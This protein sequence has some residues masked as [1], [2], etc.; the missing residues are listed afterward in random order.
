MTVGAYAA[1]TSVRQGDL[2]DFCL[3]PGRVPV[4]IRDV[5]TGT[6]VH[7]GIAAGPKWTIRAPWPSSLY[8]AEFGDD[9]D[10]RSRPHFVVRPAD[11]GSTAAILVSVPFPT[12]EAYNHLGVPGQG[13]YLTEQPDRAVRVRFDRPGGGPVTAGGWDLP[14]YRWLSATG[15]TVEY[16]SALDLHTG[17]AA[18]DSYRL[19][20]C[21]GHDEYWSWE[22]R[23][24]VEAFVDAG[25]NLAFFTGNT[26]WWQ[27]RFSDDLRTMICYRDAVRDPVAAVHPNRTTVEW[28]S[29]PV[30]RAENSMTGVSF[31]RGA[32]CW[33]D[34][35][36][37]DT[38]GYTA[39]FA[40]HWVFEGTG[41]CDGQEF[42]TGAVGYET[43]AADFEELDG[44]PRVTG[45]DGTPPDFVVL[46][47]ADLRHWRRYGQGG[48]A[49]MGIF[50]R[51]R[52]TVFNAA[53]VN[54]ANR[55][56]DPI[57]ARITANVVDR[58]AAPTA[59]SEDW[60]DI[61]SSAGIR[62]LAA[63]EHRLFGVTGSGALTTRD[64]CAQNLAWRT[65]DT[66]PGL[67]SV[68]A[69]REAIVGCPVGLYGLF[70]DDTVA[71]RE[72]LSEPA[73]WEPFCRVPAG[74]ID[75]AVC[76]Q[77]LFAVTADGVLW[78]VPLATPHD[79]GA[80]R[81]A[82]DAADVIS[83]AGVSG[84]L[85]AVTGRGGVRSRL[86]A[87]GS[88][89]VDGG[90]GPGATA[91]AGYAGALIACCADGRLRRRAASG[92]GE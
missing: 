59:V 11:P 18:L 17:A 30:N 74:T 50:R 8:R 73:P 54:W 45:R 9:D 34:M 31:R 2:L 24:S 80:W 89:W 65:V 33:E 41:L 88:E 77:S 83:L 13:L 90:C 85:F 57:V 58:L 70:G 60:E 64:Y 5:A 42:A 22:M 53:T 47:T 69:P 6:A 71:F 56:G 23:D 39:R 48:H 32:G 38:A 81:C 51:G 79:A 92:M 66:A 14:F 43:D 68:A 72:P 4:S 87:D 91:L 62:A 40:Q 19:L 46:A 3:P 21:A 55:L 35:A 44:V 37:V 1:H 28:S 49:T 52:G 63:C 76:Y 36:Q 82:G 16:C 61:G 84:R 15:R 20:I 25:G 7:T 67:R 86:C 12:W 10:E 27:V 26:C 29:A 75:I 78:S